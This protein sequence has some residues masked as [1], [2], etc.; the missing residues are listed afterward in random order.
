MVSV[1]SPGNS[2]I[3]PVLTSTFGASTLR[4]PKVFFQSSIPIPALQAAYN[5]MWR[6]LKR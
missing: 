5:Q 1:N 4:V 2:N 6:R 3:V